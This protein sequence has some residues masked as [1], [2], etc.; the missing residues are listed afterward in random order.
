[1]AGPRNYPGLAALRFLLGMAE[2]IVTPGFTLL[3]ARF[4]TRQEQALRIGIWYCCNG[5]GS[6][7]GGLLGYGVGHITNT[8]IPNWAWIFI[9]NGS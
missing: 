3:C 9:V 4:Y 5:L 6:M 7:L 1:M 2:S 8:G